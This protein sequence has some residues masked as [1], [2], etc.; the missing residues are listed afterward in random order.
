MV[1]LNTIITALLFLLLF[2]AVRWL[3][4]LRLLAAPL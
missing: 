2:E 3:I 1:V 4:A